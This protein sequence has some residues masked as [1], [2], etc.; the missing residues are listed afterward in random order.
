MD[1]P[2]HAADLTGSDVHGRDGEYLG[3]VAEVYVADATHRP[4]WIRVRTG[5]LGT[6]KNFAPLH[7]A[8]FCRGRLVLCCSG[9]AVRTAPRVGTEHGHLSNTEGA[10][11][12]AHYGLRAGEFVPPRAAE[13]TV[14][15]G[16]KRC[17]FLPR[18]FGGDRAPRT[19]EHATDTRRSSGHLRPYWTMGS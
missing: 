8:V 9:S 3:R 17:R 6:R 1:E 13:S 5:A 10:R 2:P 11:L 14:T 18:P 4:E 16:G 7:A 12:C 15:A 19:A